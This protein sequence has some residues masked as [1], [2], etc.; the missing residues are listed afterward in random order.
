MFEHPDHPGMTAAMNEA[1]MTPAS[2]KAK[3]KSKLDDFGVTPKSE[4]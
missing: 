1:D 3:M 2:V 4:K